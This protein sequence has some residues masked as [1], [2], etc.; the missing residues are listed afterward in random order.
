[1]NHVNTDHPLYKKNLTFK[2]KLKYLTEN[3]AIELCALLG[4][5][6]NKIFHQHTEFL[7]LGMNSYK[8][9]LENIN[10]NMLDKAYN[11]EKIG[12]LKIISEID[13]AYLAGVNLFTHSPQKNSKSEKYPLKGESLLDFPDEYIL[14][15]LETTGYYPASDKIIEIGLAKVKNNE[16]I[17]SFSSLIN[18][19]IEI[20]PYI[21]EKTGITN[22][23]VSTA[24]TIDDVLPQALR[25]IGDSVII[26]YN[27]NFDIHFLYNN[28]MN[29][30]NKPFANDFVDVMRL[31]KKCLPFL[32][33]KKLATVC[34]YFEIDKT[35]HP[36][37]YQDCV[38][39]FQCYQKIKD[40]IISEYGSFDNFFKTA[41]KKKK[42]YKNYYINAKANAKEIKTEKTEFNKESPLY[43]KYFVFTGALEKLTRKEAMQMVVDVGG[44]CENNVT[45]KTN[46]LV[47]GGLENAPVK[48]K[49]SSK[50]IKAEKLIEEEQDLKII[51]EKKFFAML[52]E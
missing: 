42:K 18:P 10:S 40:F 31:T 38:I 15:D 52:T 45:K 41:F 48:N 36:R 23:M 51:S 33:N 8:R 13:F 14:L 3:K 21:E 6:Y 12:S 29:L 26:G 5:K 4:T 9:Y 1:M 28:M 19:K 44:F 30:Y 22:E 47:V 11:L 7:I 24:P 37:A 17:D 32:P 43:E 34:D 27:V 16:I 35:G 20:D 50:L 2:G 49:K 39:T 46:F 25:F